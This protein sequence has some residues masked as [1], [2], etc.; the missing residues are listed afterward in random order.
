MDH[1][2]LP[3]DSLAHPPWQVP[4]SGSKSQTYDDLGFL[5][6]PERAGFDISRLFTEGYSYLS[7]EELSLFLQEW[8]WFRL[9]GETLGIGSR[10]HISQKIASRAAFITEGEDGA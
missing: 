6:Y 7:L 10:V 1:L 8:L 2:P 9:L 5:T 3:I 4:F